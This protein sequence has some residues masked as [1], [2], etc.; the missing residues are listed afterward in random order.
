[1]NLRIHKYDLEAIDT[2]SLYLKK[3][4]E[5]L[6]VG[7]QRGELKV[8]VVEDLDQPTQE[9]REFQIRGTGHDIRQRAHHRYID[10]VINDEGTLVWHIFL[11]T[12]PEYE[13]I[14]N[15]ENEAQG[16]GQTEH[17]NV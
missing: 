14:D 5:I 17:F 1:M 12:V 8:W 10:T 16:V 13:L 2:V 4:A 11:R 6:K 7:F 9:A 15:L 3:D